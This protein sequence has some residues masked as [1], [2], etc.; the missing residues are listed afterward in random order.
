MKRK[1]HNILYTGS[2]KPLGTA[3]PLVGTEADEVITE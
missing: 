3:K 2:L 1:I